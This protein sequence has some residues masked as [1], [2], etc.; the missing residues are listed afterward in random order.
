MEMELQEQGM[1]V[2]VAVEMHLTMVTALEE[3]ANPE[4][5]LLSG[6]KYR[7]SLN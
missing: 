3:Q 5:Q 2:V 6:R 4:L 1:E 7:D